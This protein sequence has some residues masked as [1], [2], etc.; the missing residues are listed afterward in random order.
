MIPLDPEE[1][2]GSACW[3]AIRKVLTMLACLYIG[4]LCGLVGLLAAETVSTWFD[5]FFTEMPAY[6]FGAEL[7]LLPFWTLGSAAA[8]LALPNILCA[9]VYYFTTEIPSRKRFIQFATIHQ[10]AFVLALLEWYSFPS[11]F[12]SGAVEVI[13][14]LLGGLFFQVMAWGAFYYCSLLVRSRQGRNHEEHLMTVAAENA[15]WR[16]RL[17]EAEFIP[18]PPSGPEPPRARPL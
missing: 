4:S 5:S 14:S 8:F 9:S 12:G 11:I 18:A 16:R 2:F 3:E 6:E 15:V 1:I 13:V 10:I 17:E 7:F